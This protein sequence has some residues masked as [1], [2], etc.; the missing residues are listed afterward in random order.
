MIGTVLAILGLQLA[1][2]VVQESPDDIPTLIEERFVC[3]TFN[4]EACKTG[5]I[6]E[7]Y[8]ENI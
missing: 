3:K 8:E 1:I 5:I 4:I 2:T 7:H 6:E